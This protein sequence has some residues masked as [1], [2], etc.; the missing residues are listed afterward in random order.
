VLGRSVTYCAKLTTA[1]A[2]EVAEPLSGFDPDPRFHQKPDRPGV[3]A[4]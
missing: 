2:R 3:S 4:G 1:E